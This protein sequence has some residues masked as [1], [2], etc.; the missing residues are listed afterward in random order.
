MSHKN[1]SNLK[2]WKSGQSGNPAGR[3]PGSKNVSTIARQLLEQDANT[4][5]LSS[6]NIAELTNGKPTIYTQAIV[7]AMLKRSL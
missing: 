5:L 4:N 7:L 3:K 2:S 6:A 1:F